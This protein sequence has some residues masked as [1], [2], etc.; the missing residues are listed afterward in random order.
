MEDRLNGLN[1]FPSDMTFQTFLLDGN[2]KVVVLDNPVHNAAV[3]ELYLKRITGRETAT[4]QPTTA[5]AEAT[6]IDLGVF[7]RTEK[8]KATFIIRNTG[9]APLVIS[10][11]T[12]SC[13]CTAATYDKRP[14]SPGAT[15][16]V[17]VEI[18][19]EQTGLFEETVTLTGN[20]S[21]PVVLIIRGQ[22]RQ[23]EKERLACNPK[24]HKASSPGCP[25]NKERRCMVAQ[26]YK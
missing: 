13:G 5:A 20:I 19:P 16:R 3:K 22:T 7:D 26:R 11:V 14:V 2:N 23:R 15:L 24:M 10:D 4:V 12:T 6:E 8:Q 9:N 21:E 18:H 17:E 25:S 1:R